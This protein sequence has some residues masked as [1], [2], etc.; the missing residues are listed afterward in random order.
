VIVAAVDVRIARLP[1]DASEVREGNQRALATLEPQLLEILQVAARLLPKDHAEVDLFAPVVDGGGDSPVERVPDGVADRR[2]VEAQQIGLL[3]V[4]DDAGLVLAGLEI[5]R[6]VPAALDAGDVGLD[7]LR[8]GTQ[9]LEIVT[10]EVKLHRGLEGRAFAP[11]LEA[12]LGR[13]GDPRDGLAIFVHDLQSRSLAFE[14][15][16]QVEDDL[17]DVRP[18]PEVV[19]GELTGSDPPDDREHLLVGKLESRPLELRHHAARFLQL[20]SHGHLHGDSE[21]LDVAR[22]E[23]HE[24]HEG[25]GE[26]DAA[27]RQGDDRGD[28]Q[29]TPVEGEVQQA[30]VGAAQALQPAVR[31]P[32]LRAG[33]SRPGEVGDVRG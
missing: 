3:L 17:A 31:D 26:D 27:G 9:D 23:Q 7:L 1:L 29:V 25:V 10:P 14:A 28:A 16:G 24:G 21:L 11:F 20:G 6:D 18:G 13:S 2:H 33:G 30:E 32:P 19:V 15:I 8:D 4:D 22:W 12:D 5:V